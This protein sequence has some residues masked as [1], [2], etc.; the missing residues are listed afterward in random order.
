LARQLIACLG[1]ESAIH[2]CKVNG[3][4]GIHDAVLCEDAEA[5]AAAE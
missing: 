4:A 2:V 1:R 3:W 5:A